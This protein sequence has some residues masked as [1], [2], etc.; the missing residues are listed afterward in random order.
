MLF[1]RAQVPFESSPPAYDSYKKFEPQLPPPYSNNIN[2][3]ASTQPPVLY[4]ANGESIN[5]V[6]PVLP[7]RY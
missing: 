5:F 4:T 6:Y 2:K 7:N 1:Q 3:N